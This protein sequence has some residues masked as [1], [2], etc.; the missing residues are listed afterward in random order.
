V[1]LAFLAPTL[2]MPLLLLPVHLVW[3][4][5]II[6]P[7]SA[8]VFQAEPA[9]PGLMQRPP[10]APSAPLL[11]RAA[12]IRSVLAGAVLTAGVMSLYWAR[13]P[14]GEVEAR[15]IAWAAL[16]IGYQVLVFIEWAALRGKRS[17]LLPRKPLVWVV[18][19]LCGL[20]LPVAMAIGPLA[21]GLHL[22]MLSG[23]DWASAL[24]VGLA[25]TSWRAVIDHLWPAS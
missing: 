15:S 8:V 4:E 13:Q 24:G 2:G 21:R 18:W 3:L 23:S 6:H 17:S 5:L 11:P 7:V 9:A 12:I 14:A 20:S 10:R 19:G 25:A 16:L 22:Q 1:A